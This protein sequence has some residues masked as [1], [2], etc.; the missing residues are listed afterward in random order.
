MIDVNVF[1]KSI[2][3]SWLRRLISS[4]A[5]WAKMHRAETFPYTFN[6]VN[7]NHDDLVKARALCKNSFWKDIYASV[8]KEHFNSTPGGV[9]NITN[10]W[11]AP[12]K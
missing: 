5:T 4:E 1:W 10:K 12:N 11:R 9:H 6:P 8:Q 7:S 3:M 2:G